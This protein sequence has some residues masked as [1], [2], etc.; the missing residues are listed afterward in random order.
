MRFDVDRRNRVRLSV[1]VIDKEGA[2]EAFAIWL[3]ETADTFHAG[4]D[5]AGGNVTSTER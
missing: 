4:T 1:H 3:T 5:S 2:R